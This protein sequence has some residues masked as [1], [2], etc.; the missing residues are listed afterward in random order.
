MQAPMNSTMLGCLSRCMSA[1]SALNSCTI[2]MA[3]PT[4]VSLDT[5]K[6]A[7][8]HSLTHPEKKTTSQ[9]QAN[10]AHLHHNLHG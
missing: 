10:V 4:F 6:V 7:V 1:T 5:L 8:S 9:V 2:S 3:H